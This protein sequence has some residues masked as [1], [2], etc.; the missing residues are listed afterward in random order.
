MVG[1]DMR[2]SSLI[3]VL[4]GLGCEVKLVRPDG[5]DVTVPDL[6][7]KDLKLT[8][9]GPAPPPAPLVAMIKEHRNT[10]VHEL[11]SPSLWSPADWVHHFH[12]RAAILEHEEGL[13]RAAAEAEALQ[14][15]FQMWCG[16]RCW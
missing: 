2:A 6:D 13:G 12:E 1:D 16:R 15:C 4:Q 9:E 11:K 8:I 3:E 10:I 7:R 5:R 14:G